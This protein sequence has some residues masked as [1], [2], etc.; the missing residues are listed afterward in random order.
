MKQEQLK[1]IGVASF[2]GNFVE[3][4]DYASYGYLATII[5]VVFFPQTDQTTGL[6]ITFSVFAI[7]FL[8][9]PLGGFFWG[10]FGDRFGRRKALSMSII[11]MSLSTM[12]IGFIP[13]YEYIGITAPLLL[14]LARLAQGFSAS[15]EYAGAAI[16]L[17]ESAPSGKRGHYASLVP[18]STASGLLFGSLLVTG[19][20]SVL[21]TS[22]LHDWG[23]RIPF[24]L[25]GPFGVIGYYIR[26]HLNESPDF[27]RLQKKLK[28]SIKFTTTLKL[29]C[30]NYKKQLL[31]GFGLTSLNATGFYLLLSY[32]PTYYISELNI[33][34]QHSFIVS[35]LS[36]FIY[37]FMVLIIGALSDKWGRKV[38]LAMA[39][40]CFII[41]TVP[42]FLLLNYYGNSFLMLV[43]VQCLFGLFMAMNDGTIACY[44]SELFP[45][46][47]RYSSFALCFNSA[48][49]LL[50]GTAPLVA[51]QLIS[52]TNSP[53]APAY[54][55]VFVACIAAISIYFSHETA[56]KCGTDHECV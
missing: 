55:L 13:S 28:H 41:F 42:L 43:L 1:K 30:K 15:G 45:V 47:I 27:I 25:S 54:Y 5:A 35:S 33:S 37:I 10:Y 31:I 3:W 40:A 12:F 16:F 21:E 49:T 34:S 51:T 44:L 48:N 23:W 11:I 6:L 20:Y 22:Q 52:I 29:I 32:M 39:S 8:I 50:G 26:T 24:L 38:M 17:T 36:L 9:R 18:A 53:I 7:S 2:I 56:N 14:L 19:L 4:F 46:E